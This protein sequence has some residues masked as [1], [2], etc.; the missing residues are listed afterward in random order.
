MET[1]EC[2]HLPIK[3]LTACRTYVVLAVSGAL[4]LYQNLRSDSP[5]NLHTAQQ[6]ELEMSANHVS[7]YVCKGDEKIKTLL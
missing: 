6:S 5:T 2:L 7:F 1:R 3:K 4:P